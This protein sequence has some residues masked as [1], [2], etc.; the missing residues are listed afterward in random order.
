MRPDIYWRINFGKDNRTESILF[1][2]D[3]TH[4]DVDILLRAMAYM[5]EKWPRVKV[6]SITRVHVS[7]VKV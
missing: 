2:S 7:V 1:T 6:T 4:E 5:N 3:E